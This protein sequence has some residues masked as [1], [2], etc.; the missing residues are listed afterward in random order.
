MATFNGID[1]WTHGVLFSKNITCCLFTKTYD[2]LRKKGKRVCKPRKIFFQNNCFYVK[3][4]MKS[5][6]GNF[7]WFVHVLSITVYLFLQSN[8]IAFLIYVLY[9]AGLNLLFNTDLGIISELKVI[10]VKLLHLILTDWIYAILWP[11]FIISIT[12]NEFHKCV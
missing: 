4:K 7:K 12:L 6:F 2:F 9:A 11:V 8:K 1:K 3:R 5:T 10:S